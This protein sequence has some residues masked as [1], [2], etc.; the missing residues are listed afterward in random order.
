MSRLLKRTM[1]I[2]AAIITLF[3]MVSLVASNSTLDSKNNNFNNIYQAV[4]T[5]SS[6]VY[7]LFT[8][9]GVDAYG[10][11][12]FET[13]D[14]YN[15]TQNSDSYYLGLNTDSVTRYSLT[16]SI[17]SPVC[18]L[19]K[20]HGNYTFSMDYFSN[21]V[22]ESLAGK[23]EVLAT[24]DGENYY[25]LDTVN[26]VWDNNSG[27]YNNFSIDICNCVKQIKIRAKVLY[28][29]DIDKGISVKNM[30]IL[31][32]SQLNLEV[33]NFTTTIADS[34]FIANSTKQTPEFEVVCDNWDYQYDVI[35]QVYKEGILTD[36][37]GKGTYMMYVI[38]FSPDSKIVDI[39]KKQFTI[40]PINIDHFIIEYYANDL[41]CL[42][43]DIKVFDFDDNDVSA[44]V[45]EIGCV[46]NGMGNDRMLK[47]TVHSS[48]NN[49][50]FIQSGITI[51]N[52]DTHVVNMAAKQEYT[53]TGLPIDIIST[54]T[55]SSVI[56]YDY[57]TTTGETYE[58]STPT[59]VGSYLVSMNS[60]GILISTAT[61][62]I[63]PKEI[64]NITYNFPQI[65]KNFDG[66]YELNNVNKNDF[67]FEGLVEND[68]SILLDGLYL[69]RLDGVANVISDK[70]DLGNNYIYNPSTNFNLS[71]KIN[72]VN[73]TLSSNIDE[74]IV[75]E[76]KHII[77]ANE[78]EYNGDINASIN[79]IEYMQTI[80]ALKKHL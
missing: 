61:V 21:R 35:T 55:A 43:R 71:C 49:E 47:I 48:E 80:I 27:L 64:T 16:L 1:I 36:S 65:S 30:Q 9:I 23:I 51:P 42:I 4:P 57:S 77:R 3:I 11:W 53:Y 6:E 74:N 5:A 37:I 17:N 29:C 72:R 7:D 67:T 44:L 50:I 33:P 38:I 78:R 15:W 45:G 68:T 22:D 34:D 18:N 26:R 52:K 73:I 59:D 8:D 70:V 66:T 25:L 39:T 60:D 69:D 13:I 24:N 19:N 63:T 41:A 76:D 31:P 12:E 2:I 75:G 28:G 32:K 10:S 79:F 58:N 46:I 14:T 40:T 20:A 62:I 56:T 54:D